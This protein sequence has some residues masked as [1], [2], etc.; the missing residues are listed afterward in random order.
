M[1]S[2]E[3]RAAHWASATIPRSIARLPRD[4][5]GYPIP[6]FAL[7]RDGVH[8]FAVV[9]SDRVVRC[10]T[11]RRCG[12]CGEKLAALGWF[13]GGPKS[14][15]ARRSFDAPMHLDCAQF[16]IAAC[17]HLALQGA[18]Y[19]SARGV[20][21]GEGTMVTEQ[22]SDQ[23]PDRYALMGTPRFSMNYASG[24][25]IEFKR[26]EIVHWYEYVDGRLLKA[27]SK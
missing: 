3:V 13:I 15:A 25:V 10:V 16:S 8:D 21:S 9:D 24:G 20:D 27:G 26:P 7:E 12:I 4:P 18:R 22:V 17:P 23:K 14:L 1:T 2:S 11:E 19:R 5:R 6:F